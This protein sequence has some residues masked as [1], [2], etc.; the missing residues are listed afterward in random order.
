MIFNRFKLNWG[1]KQGFPWLKLCPKLQQSV[2]QICKIDNKEVKSQSVSFSVYVSDS[3]QSHGY[4]NQ[5]SLFRDSPGRATGCIPFSRGSSQ[6]RNQTWVYSFVGKIFTSE[7]PRKPII[8]KA[9]KNSHKPILTLKK[10]NGDAKTTHDEILAVIYFHTGRKKRRCWFEIWQ[11][12]VH[13]F[14]RALCLPLFYDF[15]SLLYSWRLFGIKLFHW[16]VIPYKSLEIIIAFSTKATFIY[17]HSRFLLLESTQQTI[18]NLVLFLKMN[19]H[20]L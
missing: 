17:L 7:L 2:S 13:P 1:V 4:G 6:S 9:L 8:K 20:C 18:Q 5:V 11:L 3:L 15:R 12:K 19:M 10:K 16:T 14:P